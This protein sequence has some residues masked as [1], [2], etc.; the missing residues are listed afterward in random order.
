SVPASI[1]QRGSASS[2]FGGAGG[3]DSRASVSSLQG[4]RSA[5]Q[6]DRVPAT[7]AS[8]ASDDKTTM[9]GLNER[10]KN[11]LGTVAQLE[12]SN[13]DLEEKIKDLLKKRELLGEH[14]WKEIEK[15]LAQLRQQVR[16]KTM[17]N[18]RLLLLIDTCKLTN[19]DLKNKM[20]IEQTLRQNVEHDLNDLRKVT[21]DTSLA[22]LHLEGQI[23]SVK[24]ELAFLRKDHREDVATL[25]KR[26]K[27]SDVIVEMDSA[28][29]DLKN[30]VNKIRVQYEKVAQKNLEDTEAWY[31]DKFD[32]IKVEVAKN[33]ETLQS[34]RLELSELRRTKQLLEIDV[35]TMNKTIQS[36]EKSL[37]DLGGRY[38]QELARLAQLVH[39]L[40]SE[41]ANVRDQVEHQADEYQALLNIKMKLEAEIESYRTLLQ[42]IDDRFDTLTG[43]IIRRLPVRIPIR[44]VATEVP[45][46]KA[47]SPHTAPQAPVMAAHCS[48][49]VMVKS[50]GHISLCHCVLRCSVS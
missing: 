17:E 11:Y 33:T 38:G 14:N 35:E 16:D 26:V 41:L 4:L 32:N 28:E 18:A 6:R 40:E 47:P 5:M 36:L 1:M 23:E 27:E 30:S 8:P 46:S 50:R 20:E 3:R 10:L 22:K 45:L 15:P 43:P 34:G 29:S 42:S 13:Q 12:K 25:R 48:P 39:R 9:K 7:S 2:M 44:Q 24:E 37:K 21:D 49:R 19:E 31:N